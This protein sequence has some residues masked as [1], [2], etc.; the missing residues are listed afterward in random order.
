MGMENTEPCRNNKQKTL[1][2]I[3]LTIIIPTHNRA[4]SLRDNIM[5]LLNSD[6]AFELLVVDDGSIDETEKVVK[7]LEDPRITYC[8]HSFK[9]GYAKSMNEGIRKAKNSHIVLCEDDAF[10]LNPN[11]FSETALLEMDHKN[12]VATHLLAKGKEMKLTIIERFK[13][14]FAEPLTG[15]VYIYS[16]HERRIVRFCNACFGFNKDEIETRFDETSYVGNAFRIESDF[17]IRARKE[18]A[19]IIYNPSLVIDHKRYPT[20]GHRVQDK[21]IFLYQC[22]IN[23]MIFLRK[24]YSLWNVYLYVLLKFLISPAKW[25]VVRNAFKAHLHLPV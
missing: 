18:G 5:S 10:I 17:Q 6:Y 2:P 19:K 24:H 1:N 20:G 25:F 22:M 16:G 13:R 8:K 12:I 3:N 9:C 15:E 21:N 14:F 7:S 11:K 23:H 4:E